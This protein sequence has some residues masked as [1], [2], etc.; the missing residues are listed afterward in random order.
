MIH[1][2]IRTACVIAA[3]AVAASLV[4]EVRFQFA[5]IDTA[6][7]QAVAF[8]PPPALAA[9]APAPPGR[10]RAVGRAILDLADAG[11]RVVR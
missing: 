9:P 1:D 7:R 11:L 3:M 6:Q 5:A 10:L 8:V 4:V 2:L